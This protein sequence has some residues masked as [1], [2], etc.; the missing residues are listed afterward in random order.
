MVYALTW[1]LPIIPEGM[2]NIPYFVFKYQ[3]KVFKFKLH[4]VWRILT[5]VYVHA[6]LLILLFSLISYVPSA[7]NMEKRQGT[8]RQAWKFFINSAIIG[9]FY[10]VLSLIAS[11]IHEKFFLI[12]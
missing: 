2:M 6:Q 4:I 7:V 12:P 10:Q 5:G 11:L 8:V 1:I 9:T 3:S